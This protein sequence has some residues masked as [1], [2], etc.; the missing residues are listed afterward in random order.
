MQMRGA[1]F[2]FSDEAGGGEWSW[3]RVAFR[4]RL[5]KESGLGERKKGGQQLLG[6]PGWGS[7]SAVVGGEKGKS[8]GGP[9]LRAHFFRQN[10][11]PGTECG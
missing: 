1:E 10:R 7:Q 2:A 6:S 8:A 11:L 5:R 4:D 9:R 3:G